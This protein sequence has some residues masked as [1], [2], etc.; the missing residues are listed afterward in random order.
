MSRRG[1]RSVEVSGQHKLLLQEKAGQLQPEL[2]QRKNVRRAEQV[3]LGM[4]QSTG[5]KV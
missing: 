3:L 5:Q 1:Q 4:P 2:F